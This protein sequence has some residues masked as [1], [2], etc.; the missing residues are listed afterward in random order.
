MIIFSHLWTLLIREVVQK[1]F[2][3][4]LTGL[5][6]LLLQPLYAQKE[7]AVWYFGDHAG[8]DFNQ[9]Y[10]KPLTDGQIDTHE[11][12]A[13]ISDK[14]GKLLFYTDGQTVYNRAHKVMLNGTGLLGNITSTQSSI[15][16]PWPNSTTKYCIF[17]LDKAGTP[18]NPGNGLKYS[19]VEMT[20]DNGL[21]GITQ[22]NLSP[23][24]VERVLFTEKIAAIKSK[25]GKYYWIITH[26]FDNWAFDEFKLTENGL[27]YEAQV[28]EGSVY[29]YDPT[30]LNNRGAT[31]Y[32]KS[33]PKGDFIATAVEGGHFFELFSFDNENGRI[34]Q[35]AKLGAGN[36]EDPNGEI[37][38]AYG[39]EFSP[40]GNFLYGSTR[41][42]GFIYQWDITLPDQLSIQ[43]SA[44]ILRE[45]ASI[46]V[47]AL[48]LG[49]N[50]KIYVTLSGQPYL[51]VI[52]SPIQKSCN[53]IEHGTTLLDNA[54]GLGGKSYF[55]LPTFL[56]DFFQAAKFYYESTCQNDTTKFYVSAN[57][58]TLDGLPQWLFYDE[59]GINLVGK[60]TVDP[61]TLEGTYQFT[62]AGKYMVKFSVRQFGSDITQDQVIT[63][64]PLPEL[65]FPDT[66]S[67]CKGSPAR[68][69]AGDG[70]F[71]LWRDN[72]NLS[73]YRVREVYN[74]G[75]Y[76]VTVTH[77]NGCMA[78]DS[79]YVKEKP[80][81]VIKDPHVSPAACGGTNGSIT[82]EMDKP[83]GQFTFVWK[84]F[85]DNKTN[86]VTSLQGGLYEVTITDTT[87]LCSITPKIAV[88]EENAPDV[89]IASSITGAVCAGTKVRLTAE[90]AANYLWDTPA[91]DTVNQLVV[92]PWT[93][94]T[95]R[96][97]GYS[98]D[99]ITQKECSGFGE[100]TII[101][102]PYTLPQLG[103]DRLNNCMGDTIWLDGSSEFMSWKWSNGDTT[104]YV[105]IV[106]SEPQLILF[107]TDKNQCT[108]TD[109][110]KVVVKPLPIVKLPKDIIACHGPAIDLSGGKGDSYLWSRGDTTEHIQ[111][112][113]T[114]D[115]VLTI[116]TN[117]CT[118][119]DTVN[120]TIKPLPLVNLG[121]DTT[122]CAMDPIKL[123]G[124]K[125]DH[126]IW[127]TGD[128]TRQIL[129]GTSGVYTL[130]ITLDGC[131]QSDTLNLTIKPL[132]KVDLGKDAIY[133]KSNAIPLSGGLGDSYKWNTGAVTQTI[134][135]DTTGQYIL[136]IT[137]NGCANSDTVRIQ[138]ND[139][140]KLVIDSVTT[141]PVTCPGSRDGSL[142]IYARGSGKKYEYSLD[143]GNTY[144][145]SPLFEGLYG[146]NSFQLVVR[147]DSA[148]TVR[149]PKDISFSEPDSIKIKY[150]L[151]SP[152]CET[153]PDGEIHLSVSGGTPPYSILWSTNDTV[154]YLSGMELGKYLVWVTDASR[155]RD[156]ALIDLTLDFPPF[157]VPNAFTP[158]GDGYN[159]TW[160]IPALKDFTTCEMKIFSSTGKLI[161]WADTG[162][163]TAW[164]GKDKSG[165]VLPMGTY[166]YLLWLQPGLKPLK[167]S[168]SIL[169]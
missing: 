41:K 102:L 15:V 123:S 121:K 107:A 125:G 113:E 94:T 68:L 127:S 65:N 63:I 71:Y 77:Y 24:G 141:S 52:S 159:E 114:G 16:I 2:F 87:T 112:Y 17:T 92:A 66:T 19:I 13:S 161:W 35:L 62:K 58:Q 90:G 6:L 93:T 134:N 14:N 124:G 109:T 151:V 38:N 76:F 83:T 28:L 31:G 79:T 138:V 162:Y 156:H 75:T 98:R 45:N 136:S 3:F 32:I 118:N 12:V 47:G 163:T 148:C 105:E 106:K 146:N 129:A 158:N 122:V 9:Q 128:S 130:T 50:G 43:R 101:V 54:T 120:V 8:L 104:R 11:G 108:F 167:G 110:I 60:A 111:V 5:A 133:C 132:P 72:N 91:K 166:Y 147:E 119:S 39:V 115:Y 95:Y 142:K 55:G 153:C 33:S 168:V 23:P 103:P 46:L 37:N 70:A 20:E 116:K 169:R 69:D 137:K 51:G 100:V 135:I 82:I 140:A 57:K 56:S 131:T 164:D 4:F 144:Y 26:E 78:S 53:Y 67:L 25:D 86:R 22:K 88:S 59:A 49:P 21:G 160:Q 85:P 48:Q 84:D 42:G 150:R 74:P 117:G 81:P 61:N 30:D 18:L 154:T 64:F 157:Q 149:Y 80:V 99:P 143:N 155:C 73:V 1:R 7:G 126:Y 152:S 96:V 139:P 10:P 29:R 34:R 165:N 44:Q 27:N 40:T 89:K 145:D 36:N 97:K